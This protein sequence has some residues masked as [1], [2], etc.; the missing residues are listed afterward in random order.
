[1]RTC[2]VDDCDRKHDAKGYCKKHYKRFSKRGTVDSVVPQVRICSISNCNNKHDARGY[3][4]T[5]YRKFI[6][7]GSDKHLTDITRAQGRKGIVRLGYFHVYR[8]DHPMSTSSGYLREHRL[9][10]AD[11]LGRIL[12]PNETVHHKNGNKLDNRIEN[13]EL[14]VG[15]H[16]N[17]QS[18]EDMVEWARDILD[19]YGHMYPL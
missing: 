8:P 13:L 2:S 5:H 9:V 6:R 4:K 16:G 17:S 7:R 14:M 10:M 18:V 15:S 3:C 11:H 1:M 19:R 12:H